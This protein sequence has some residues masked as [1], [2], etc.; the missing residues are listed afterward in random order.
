MKIIV[1]LITIH[2]TY[3]YLTHFFI[4]LYVV[5]RRQVGSNEIL[6]VDQD[7]FLSAASSLRS[8]R[9]DGNRLRNVPVEAL[10]P[11]NAHLEVL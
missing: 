6:Q 5:T 9:L 2:F 8:L 10:R 4:V 11:L 1:V 3:I 7:A